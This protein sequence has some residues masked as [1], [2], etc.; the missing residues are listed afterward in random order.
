MLEEFPVK[1]IGFYLPDWLDALG[2]DNKMKSA[3]YDAIKMH[4]D[5]IRSIKE[6][7]FGDKEHRGAGIYKLCGREVDGA[8]GTAMSPPC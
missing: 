4:C 3:L 1:S 6:Y 5:G 8:W 2:G 7:P